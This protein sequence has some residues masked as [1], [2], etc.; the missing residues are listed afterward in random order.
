MR[1]LLTS[2][3]NNVYANT[4]VASDRFGKPQL[5][6]RFTLSWQHAGVYSV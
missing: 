5:N 2:Y 3:E 1:L 4:V 6:N